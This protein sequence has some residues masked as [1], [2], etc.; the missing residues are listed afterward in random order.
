MSTYGSMVSMNNVIPWTT[1]HFLKFLQIAQLI[2]HYIKIYIHSPVLETML[3]STL[4]LFFNKVDA[5]LCSSC[6]KSASQ[7]QKNGA[8][9]W[10]TGYQFLWSHALAQ[11]IFFVNFSS[12]F[13]KMTCATDARAQPA[14]TRDQKLALAI[15]EYQDNPNQS[16]LGIAKHHGVAPSTCKV[17]SKVWWT[18]TG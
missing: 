16:V 14:L 13:I 15:Q 8:C 12:L 4:Y 3:Y 5:S 1:V 2:Q 7:T 11:F 9:P 17:G 6:C 18:A 10:T